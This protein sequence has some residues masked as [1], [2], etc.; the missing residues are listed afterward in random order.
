MKKK[1]RLFALKNVKPH[2]WIKLGVEGEWEG[3]ANGTFTLTE[4]I[5]TQMVENFNRGKVDIVC[6]YEHTTLS[7][8]KA[9]A[10]GWISQKPL[11][12]K[13]KDACLWAKVAWTEEAKKHIAA[14]E[15]KYLSP[16]FVF[17]TTDQ[18]TGENIGATLHS[19]ALTNTP[20]LE[21]LG[22]IANKNKHEKGNIMP[23][24]LQAK[25]EEQ[26]NINTNQAILIQ[27]L[28]DKIK[29]LEE[30]AKEQEEATSKAE[31]ATALSKGLIS[32]SQEPWALK[33]A[34]S[35]KEGFREYLKNVT[36][37]TDYTGEQ[38]AASKAN[39]KDEAIQASKV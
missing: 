2:K 37:T 1:Y 34:L 29:A 10:S 32:A 23:K 28:E 21:G 33:Y 13:V 16:V 11:G 27:E 35:D 26:K 6:D 17:K 31:V 5:F 8:N 9:V 19:V 25:L 18:A 30:E 39:T 3:H 14:K 24:E 15:Y 12:L 36:P 20:F 7:D 4:A 22:A 38:F